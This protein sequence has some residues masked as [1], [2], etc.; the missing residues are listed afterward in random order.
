MRY[1]TGRFIGEYICGNDMTYRQTVSYFGGLSKTSVNILD[2]SRSTSK[3]CRDTK[4]NLKMC[5]M[6][7]GLWQVDDLPSVDDLSKWSTTNNAYIIV[8]SLTDLHTFNRAK[9]ILSMLPSQNLKYLV[10]NKLDLQHRREV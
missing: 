2:I 1:L 10:A 6:F 5:Y 8:Y 7:C 9:E 3:V 4:S